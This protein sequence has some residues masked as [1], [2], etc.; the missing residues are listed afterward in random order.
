MMSIRTV[1]LAAGLAATASI[2]MASATDFSTLRDDSRMH[3]ELLGASVAYLIDENCSELGL[4]KL[5]LLNK[6]F[7]LRKHAVSLGYSSKE[8]M[9]YVDSKSEQDR[10]RAIAEPLLA[11]KGVVKGQEET[12]CAAGRAE[13]AKRSFAGSL[14]YER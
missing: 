2:G 1:F 12:Y 13:I 4:R 11:S 8:V 3:S 5:R 10:F 6:A 9:A 7:S 14:L